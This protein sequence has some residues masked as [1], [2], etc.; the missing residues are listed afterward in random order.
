MFKI[1]L[2]NLLWTL[3]Y[4]GQ[5][6]VVTVP[7]EIKTDARMALDRMLTLEPRTTPARTGDSV[8]ETLTLQK[9]RV[10]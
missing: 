6:N 8:K 10:L 1:N 3:D 2:K 5:V 9:S 4:V 7:E